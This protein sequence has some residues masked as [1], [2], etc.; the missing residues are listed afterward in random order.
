MPYELLTNVWIWI[1][2]RGHE[3]CMRRMVQKKTADFAP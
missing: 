1:C 3:N 2:Y